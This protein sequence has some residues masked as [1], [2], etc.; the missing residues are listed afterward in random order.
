MPKFYKYK[1][2]QRNYDAREQET[3]IYSCYVL[4]SNVGCILIS[5]QKFNL[6]L[7]LKLYQSNQ[8]F[9]CK[10]PNFIPTVYFDWNW[11]AFL[12]M[13]MKNWKILSIVVLDDLDFTVDL[14]IYRNEH[15][16]LQKRLVCLFYSA[17]YS[18]QHEMMICQFICR[19]YLKN[20]SHVNS[21]VEY[22]MKNIFHHLYFH[23]HFLVWVAE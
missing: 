14:T 16:S 5:Q 3:N 21:F 17:I 12:V 11:C 6:C 10:L 23:T 7:K 18:I 13:A 9:V 4:I 8:V 19:I 22:I 2:Y 15:K 1:I 20:I